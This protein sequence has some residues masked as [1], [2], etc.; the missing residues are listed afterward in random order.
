MNNKKLDETFR[1]DVNHVQ[2][3]NGIHVIW[4]KEAV[5]KRIQKA[6]TGAGG[7]PKM[8]AW[9]AAMAA[10]ASL[11]VA[12][13]LSLEDI[14]FDFNSDQET[15]GNVTALIYNDAPITPITVGNNYFPTHN[16]TIKS[17]TTDIQ[18]SRSRHG[19]IPIDQILTRRAKSQVE[20][21]SLILKKSDNN[22]KLRQPN[23]GVRFEGSFSANGRYVGPSFGFGATMDLLKSEEITKKIYLGSSV[24]LIKTHGMSE[25]YSNALKKAYIVKAAFENSKSK[26][27]RTATWTSGVEFILHST[28]QSVDKPMLKLFYTR[29]IIGKLKVGPEVMFTRNFK[30]AYPGITLALS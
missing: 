13:S 14:K 26:N 4:N 1:K 20:N 10:S 12:A 23:F 16:L 27:G 18:L 8:I 2:K 28:D 3:H 19:K 21:G 6:I 5:W 17:R 24:Q 30:K 22:I 11:L 9:Y 29:G 25:G 15:I 7:G